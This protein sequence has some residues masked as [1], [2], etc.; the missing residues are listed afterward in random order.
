[1]YIYIYICIYVYMAHH[2]IMLRLI[3]F[4]LRGEREGWW[5]EHRCF[6]LISKLLRALCK[7][8]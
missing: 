1:M 8:L 5:F 7:L 3:P 6:H 4:G 2:F